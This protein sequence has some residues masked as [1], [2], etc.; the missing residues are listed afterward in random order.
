MHHGRP[1]A[2]SLDEAPSSSSHYR[3]VVSGRA[4]GIGQAIISPRELYRRGE[5]EAANIR[6]RQAKD[7][8]TV[9]QHKVARK[10]VIAIPFD[11]VRSGDQA[12]DV[13]PPTLSPEVRLSLD[14]CQSLFTDDKP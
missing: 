3:D 12:D 11:Q 10:P 2:T 5:D 1:P 14:W 8:S 7:V 9:R 4:H 6:S 13:P